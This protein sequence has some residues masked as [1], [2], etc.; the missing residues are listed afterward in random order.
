M[1]ARY[2]TKPEPL[3]TLDPNVYYTAKYLARRYQ[4]H[5]ITVLKWVTAGVLP[6]PV[7]LGPNTTRWLGSAIEAFE[8][9][10]HDAPRRT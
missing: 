7:K 8:R 4:I 10:R 1:V 6:P 2:R 3:Q 9:Q 5:P